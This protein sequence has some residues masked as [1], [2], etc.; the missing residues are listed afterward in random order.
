MVTIG[1]RTKEHGYHLQLNNDWLIAEYYTKRVLEQCHVIA[2]PTVQ[3]G[4]YPAF[5]EYPGSISLS[6]EVCRDMIVDICRSLHR[7]K[8]GIRFYVINTGIS[9]N[10]P[11]ELA[12]KVLFEQDQIIMSYTDLFIAEGNVIQSIETQ[13][14]GTHADEIETSMM[15]Y[16]APETVNLH[17]AEKDC[18]PNKLGGLTRIPPSDDPNDK[19]IGTYS[20]TGAWGD[21]TLATIEKGH[22]VIEHMV[23][24]HVEQIQQLGNPH[25]QMKDWNVKYLQHVHG[26]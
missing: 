4:Y 5:V 6:K 2:I 18:H 9:T 22:I 16:I 11:L 24:Y 8:P 19:S 14:C 7:Y 26:K 15:L 20:P 25:Y 12:R 13:E 1:A 17:L 10:Y 23:S 3:Y 21:P